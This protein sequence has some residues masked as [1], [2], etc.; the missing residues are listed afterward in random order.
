MADY[1]HVISD[2]GTLSHM[3]KIG[4]EGKTSYNC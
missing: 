4:W 2:T 1:E 3:D